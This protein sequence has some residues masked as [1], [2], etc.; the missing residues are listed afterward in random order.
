MSWLVSLQDQLPLLL[1]LSPVVGFLVTAAASR[2]DPDITR[3][4][5]IANAVCTLLILLALGWQLESHR[6]STTTAIRLAE[7]QANE[8]EDF[9]VEELR[10]GLD[11]QRVARLRQHWFAID[12]TNLFP[13]LVLVTLAIVVIGRADVGMGHGSSF[14][15]A[16]MLFEAASL[17]ALTAYDLGV[18][19]TTSFSSSLALSFLI[20][21]W[22]STERRRHAER[23][24]IAQFS[25]F[26]FIGLGF[27]ILIV[28]VPWMKVQD[29]TPLP[30]VSWHIASIVHDL[31][32]L[33]TRN[34]LA[35]HYQNEVFPWMLLVL[36]LGFAIQAG[37][38]PFHAWQ[39]DVL[40][41]SHP[42]IAALYLAGSLAASCIGWIRFVMPLAP[43][44]LASFDSIMLI[45]SMC[46]A[47]WGALRVVTSTDSRQ[48]VAYILMSLSAISL[49]GCFSFT[50]MGMSGAWLMQQQLTVILSAA[51]LT[52]GL[53]CERKDSVTSRQLESNESIEGPTSESSRIL[54]ERR[55]LA[56]KT[57]TLL[58][59]FGL[60]A[61]GLFSS[62]FIIVSELFY[63][64]FWLVIGV[65][66]TGSLIVLSMLSELDQC[67][68]GDGKSPEE[69]ASLQWSYIQWSYIL[70]S[71]LIFLIVAANLFPNHLLQQC[72]PEF[73]RVF[74]RFERST[75]ADSAEPVPVD[76]Q[77]HP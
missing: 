70:N 69:T 75:P 51:F 55:Q 53:W 28:A 31:Q 76:R 73:E 48:R 64:N 6:C 65:F 16:V 13:A 2:F 50:R 10:R 5:A 61:I 40:R 52:T 29:S 32:K 18:F 15:P 63:E 74:R 24:L 22:G 20:G 38:F 37:F 57:K 35:L 21:Q 23:F 49:L 3:H 17:G 77:L 12:G 11:R 30:G 27:T 19:L 58:L 25:G 36:S 44:L 54:A 41:H 8:S 68:A 59:F 14:F 4:L 39:M 7:Q 34:E 9:S 46:G 45:P 33:T 67:F 62:G 60:P 26:A 71:A 72:E 56:M 1:V 47:I 42:S 43:E 66:V